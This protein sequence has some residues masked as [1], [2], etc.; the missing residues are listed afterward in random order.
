LNNRGFVAALVI[1]TTILLGAT[2]P[3]KTFLITVGGTKPEVGVDLRT[4]FE[5]APEEKGLE[6]EALTELDLSY[7]NELFQVDG[8]AEMDKGGIADG[9]IALEITNS[10]SGGGAELELGPAWKS[11]ESCSLSVQLGSGSD[12]GLSAGYETDNC[13][14]AEVNTPDRELALNLEL[15]LGEESS[16][17]VSA[18][19]SSNS[20]SL[21]STPEVSEVE[22][23]GL[24]AGE[25]G[26]NPV[27]EAEGLKPVELEL[28]YEMVKP[29]LN[30]PDLS[31]EGELAW[32]FSESFVEFAPELST[33][34][35]VIFLEGEAGKF[36]KDSHRFLR[37]EEFGLSDLRLGSW[38]FEA[39]SDFTSEEVELDLFTEGKVFELGLGFLLGGTH[40]SYPIYLEELGGNLTWSPEESYEVE[41]SAETGFEEFFPEVA[42]VAD[43]SF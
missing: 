8:E 40:K 10:G 4:E 24:R 32:Q 16:A 22:L 41:F 23:D 39:V 17:G 21:I 19:F 3:F 9:A 13:P 18:T 30:D 11:V 27:L 2:L 28:N 6:T 5:A 7:G 42:V 20:G 31:L 14:G 29:L 26:L 35:G 34:E 12:R 15:G 25:F 36:P 1:L 33:K 37:I 43:Y 38:Q